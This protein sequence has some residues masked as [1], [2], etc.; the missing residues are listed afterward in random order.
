[1]EPDMTPFAKHGFILVMSALLA[2]WAATWLGGQLEFRDMRSAG[3]DPFWDRFQVLFIVSV[4]VER[5]VETYLKASGQNG[6]ETLD[7]ATRSIVKVGDASKP[8]MIAALVVSVLVALSGV[9][10]IESL[11]ILKPAATLLQAAVWNGVDIIVSAGLMAGG[12]D[13]F[14]QVAT[15]ITTGLGRIKGNLGTPELQRARNGGLASPTGALYYPVAAAA[16]F[17]THTASYTVTIERPSG[18]QAEEGTLRFSDGGVVIV[19]RCW[20]DNGNRIDPGTYQRCSKTYMS[21]SG[22]EAIYLPEAVSKVSGEKSIFLHHGSRPA[23]SLGGF[24][25]TPA[26]FKTMWTHIEPSNAMNITVIIRDM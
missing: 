24:A 15:V 12:S 13:L 9:R 14:H 1:M 17:A 19:T 5:A 26:D 2:G 22:L 23:N 3:L 11:V 8:A 21:V 16:S 20:W 4:L 18:A 6:K 10:I 7:L 25:V